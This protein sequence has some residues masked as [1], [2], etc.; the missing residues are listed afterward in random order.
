MIG[1][2]WGVARRWIVLQTVVLCEYHGEVH[3]REW[4]HYRMD[5]SECAPH[6]WRN[7]AVLGT[8]EELDGY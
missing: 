5:D 8:A 6:N 4:D 1:S 3:P 7:V 2:R